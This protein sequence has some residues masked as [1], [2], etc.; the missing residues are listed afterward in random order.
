[1]NSACRIGNH[2]ADCTPAAEHPQV[3]NQ[4]WITS[5]SNKQAKGFAGAGSNLFSSVFRSQ[6]L[7]R[8]LEQ[9]LKGDKKLDLPGLVDAMEEAGTTPTD[10]ALKAAVTTVKAWVKA[11]TQRRDKDNNGAYDNAGAI[12]IMDAWWPLWMKAQLQPTL[13]TTIFYTLPHGHLP[14]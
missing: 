14:R 10:P 1:M 9:R 12:R 2:L 5:W 11:G 6:M 3:T 7:D 4:D 13:G 8:Q